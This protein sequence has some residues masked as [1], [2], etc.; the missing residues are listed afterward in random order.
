MGVTLK[1]RPFDEE[2]HL[3]PTYPLKGRQGGRDGTSERGKKAGVLLLYVQPCSS[4]LTDA[5][6]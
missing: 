3:D 2:G 6:L 1:D 5:N 4:L